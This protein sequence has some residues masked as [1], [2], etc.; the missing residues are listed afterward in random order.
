MVLPELG[1]TGY[2]FNTRDEVAELAEEVPGG[3]TC[4]AWIKACREYDGY[5]CAGIAER[6]GERFCPPSMTVA[7]DHAGRTRMPRGANLRHLGWSAAGRAK[8]GHMRALFVLT[9][10]ESK[11][12]IAKAVA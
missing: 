3:P 2:I 6:D 8:G 1:N 10:P 4:A 9:P 5:L 12:F 11:R 7:R